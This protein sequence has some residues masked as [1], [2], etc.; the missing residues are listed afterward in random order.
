[1]K[2]YALLALLLLSGLN[3]FS[4]DPDWIVPENKTKDL[5]PFKFTDENVEA[6]KKIFEANC[7]SCHGHPGQG[8]YNSALNPV[9]GD[10]ATGKIQ[11]NS[12][13]TLHYKI[14]NGRGA[15]PAFKNILSSTDI[16]NVIAYIRSFNED[17][18]QEVA[19]KIIEGTFEGKDL[20]ILLQ[21]LKD[22]E[23]IQA[24]VSGIKDGAKI[25]VKNAEVNLF[26]KRVFG[27]LP[28][29]EVKRTDEEGYA[30]FMAP[31]DLP[32]DS[33]GYVSFVANLPNEDLYGTVNTD[34]MLQAGV[35]THP[36][37]L[38]AQ[39]AMWNTIWKAP[40]WLL[41]AYF[42][43]V[44]GVWGFIFYILFQIRNIFL[45]GKNN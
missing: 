43:V 10:P 19:K 34:T 42:T 31:A 1:M 15:M 44:A 27:N 40:V 39:R 28:V 45:L 5:S 26:A 18:A 13:G 41:I 36:V 11:N 14:T 30:Y 3:S 22:K 4:Q 2:L 23:Q 9:P 21:Y 33:A 8:D 16:W 29:D 6:G 25:P 20:K 17:Y 35:P 32:G 24:S 12:D 7:T 38:R 37:S